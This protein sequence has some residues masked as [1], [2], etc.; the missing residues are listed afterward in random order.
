MLCRKSMEKELPMT[1]QISEADLEAA[2][3]GQK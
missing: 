1:Q 2:Q 3:E